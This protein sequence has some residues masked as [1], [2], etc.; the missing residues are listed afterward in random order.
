[1]AAPTIEGTTV[2][3][4]DAAGNKVTERPM[5]GSGIGGIGKVVGSFEPDPGATQHQTIAYSDGSILSQTMGP[6]GTWQDD[7]PA[8]ILDVN[9]F[10]AWEK[11]NAGPSPGKV[12]DQQNS[13]TR[14]A[15]EKEQEKHNRAI[16]AQSVA[17]QGRIATQQGA[18]NKIAQGQLDL[19]ALKQLQDAEAARLDKVYKDKVLAGQD[20][21]T[22]NAEKQRE[23]ERWNTVNVDIPLKQEDARLAREKVAN[24]R[25]VQTSATI[26]LA[27]QQIQASQEATALGRVTLGYNAGQDAVKNAMLLMPYKV[28]PGFTDHFAQTVNSMSAGASHFQGSDFQ[29]QAPDTNALAEAGYQRAMAMFGGG[30]GGAP[31]PAPAPVGAPAAPVDPLAGVQMAPRTMPISSGGNADAGIGA[32]GVGGTPDQAEIARRLAAGYG[33]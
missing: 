3:W 30:R 27:Q 7:G 29:I 25:N 14:T 22:A 11:A 4:R 26:P 18:S 12:T 16:E 23:F 24:E 19:A 33:A 28:G 15:A 5:R 21:N 8:V 31:A 20:V 2:F 10:K 32:G 1:M 13:D 9:K 6:D 17:N